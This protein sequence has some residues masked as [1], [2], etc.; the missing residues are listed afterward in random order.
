M[1]ADFGGAAAIPQQNTPAARHDA[2]VL[3]AFPD[4]MPPSRLNGVT[5]A[6]LDTSPVV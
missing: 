3:S 2:P 5:Y 1:N 6:L 4:L